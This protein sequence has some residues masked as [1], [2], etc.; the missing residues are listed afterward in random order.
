MNH[1]NLLKQSWAIIWAV[2]AREQVKFWPDYAYDNPR[3]RVREDLPES[4]EKL[5]IPWAY[6]AVVFAEIT[7]SGTRSWAY[8]LD[9]DP[10]GN[11]RY[12]ALDTFNSVR[13]AAIQSQNFL[14]SPFF[15][16]IR[17]VIARNQRG[18]SGLESP[19]EFSLWERYS[20]KYFRGD[21]RDGKRIPSYIPRIDKATYTAASRKVYGRN[22]KGDNDSSKNFLGYIRGWFKNRGDG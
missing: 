10:N 7:K 8:N 1:L 6:L 11:G 3:T 16:W 5:A 13:E 14:L 15:S 21:S 17:N 20:G 12:L 9:Y 18:P 4:V 2:T 22:G 19:Y